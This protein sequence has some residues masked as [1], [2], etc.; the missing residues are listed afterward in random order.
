MSFLKT[1][2]NPLP[3]Q[4][5][6]PLEDTEFNKYSHLQYAVGDVTVNL[7]NLIQ[8]KTFSNSAYFSFLV[9]HQ[10]LSTSYLCRVIDFYA[11]FAKY[12]YEPECVEEY[13]CH[14]HIQ[15]TILKHE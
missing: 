5:L 1:V 3:F 2:Q 13:P 11:T 6:T 8:Q 9:R 14:D 4:F 10:I 7:I 15:P 12:K